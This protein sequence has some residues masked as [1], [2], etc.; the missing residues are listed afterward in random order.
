MH[1]TPRNLMHIVFGL[2]LTALISSSIAQTTPMDAKT[3]SVQQ[4]EA[5]AWDRKGGRG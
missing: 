5:I 1:K 2:I 4:G 3:S